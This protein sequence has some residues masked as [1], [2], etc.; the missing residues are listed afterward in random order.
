MIWALHPI[1]HTSVL[2]V[3]Q[4]MTSLSAFFVLLGLIAFTAGR[5]HL[6]Y[7]QSGAFPLIAS[8]LLGGATLGF[9]CKE[10]AALIAFYAL[11]IEY[12]FF[13][14][15]SQKETGF[16]KALFAV[17]GAMVGLAVLWMLLNPEY[18]IGGYQLR[19]FTLGERLLTETRAL[20]YYLSLLVFPASSR[21]TLFHDDFII[22]TGPF[23]PWTTMPSALFLLVVLF[24][25]FKLKNK[26]PVL[27]FAVLW[28]AAG[29]SM[30][31][32]LIGLELVHEHRNYLPIFGP[33]VG[34][35]YGASSASKYIRTPLLKTALWVM[36][37]LT[38]GFSTHALAKVWSDKQTLVQF[39]VWHHPDSAR[40]HATLAE[41]QLQERQQPLEAIIRYEQAARLAPHETAYLIQVA[42][43]G[44]YLN[45]RMADFGQFHGGEAGKTRSNSP[46]YLEVD[47][48]S[49]PPGILLDDKIHRTIAEKLQKHPVHART[50]T[51]LMLV[52]ECIRQH[53]AI[54]GHLLR[55][56]TSWHR[57][58]LDNSMTDANRAALI[59]GLVGLM[60]SQGNL[61]EAIRLG[62]LA[63]QYK[64][65]AVGIAIMQAD[66]YFQA[67]MREEAI[68]IIQELQRERPLLS[69]DDRA[70]IR[71]LLNRMGNGRDKHSDAHGLLHPGNSMNG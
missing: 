20:W 66:V 13:S 34:L 35:C 9:L 14:A 65:E 28:Y 46:V 16:R 10:N 7:A 4:R 52:S 36:V 3:V 58:A 19:E 24:S 22:S 61:D 45:A 32:S 41:F 51:S 30:E 37:A 68:A 49:N 50:V 67:G 8:G 12:A 33:V 40:A 44:A 48:S 17:T 5:I 38:L 29:H 43:I 2:Y 62:K 26:Y 57:I 6:K 39:M 15:V 63:R 27:S 64:P 18:I 71:N 59:M 55:T 42:R 1:Q 60:V 21:F 70:Q 56:A 25:A 53:P 23:S 54:C 31:S 11:V 69:S 47:R